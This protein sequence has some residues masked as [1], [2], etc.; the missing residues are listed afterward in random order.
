ML[1]RTGPTAMWRS[2]HGYTLIEVVFVAGLVATLSTVAIPRIQRALDEFRTVG[3]ARYLG[4]RLERTRAEALARSSD[5][6]L[7]FVQEGTRYRYAMYVDGNGNGVRTA[8]IS[9]GID[10]LASHEEHL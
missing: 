10:R 1:I 4:A 3:A 2:G 8:D 6:A 7:R 9:S 5:V